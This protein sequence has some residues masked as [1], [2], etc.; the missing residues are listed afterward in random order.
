MKTI[1]IVYF[2]STG[3]TALVAEALAKGIQTQP[4]VQVELLPIK[5]ESIEKGRFTDEALLAKLDSADALIFGTPT[6]MGGVAG[7]FK[8][9]IDATAGAWYQRKWVG[10]L[11]GGFTTS[12]SASGDKQGTLIYLQTFANQ[13][14]LIWVSQP[15]INSAA[16]GKN[17]GLNR[18]GSHSG[19]MGWNTNAYGAKPTL[20]AGDALTAEK[21]GAYFATQVARLR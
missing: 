10:K 6:Y 12:G 13:Q 3:Y 16:F 7:Q 4:E 9:F 21:Y 5:G 18:L 11:A 19:V 1:R 14:G 8:A 20:D 2:S 15:E 17:D